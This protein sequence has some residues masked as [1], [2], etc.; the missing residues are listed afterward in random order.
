MVRHEQAGRVRLRRVVLVLGGAVIALGALV[1]LAS[2]AE[3]AAYSGR[4]LPGVRVDGVAV[5]GEHDAAARDAITRLAAELERSPIR[6]RAGTRTFSVDPALIGFTVDVD[7]T[8]QR[9][10]DA[11]RDSNPLATATDTVLRRFRPETVALAV[12]YDDASLQGL[13]DGWSNA[14]QSGF[15]EGGLRFEGTRVV[16]IV[17][18]AGVGLERSSAEARLVRALTMGPR[19]A[20]DLPIGTITPAV[21]AAAVQTAAARARTLLATPHRIVAGTTTVELT[22]PQLAATL[23]S[24]VDGHELALTVDPAQLGTV[25]TPAFAGTLQA[26]ADATFS[27]DA[28]N[29]VS[30]VPSRDG[31]ELDTGAIG[32]S[33][34]RGVTTVVATVRQSHPAHDTAWAQRLGITGQV[35]SFTTYHPAGQPRV[36]NIHLAAD[37]LN[38]TVVEPGATFS[39]NAKLGPRTPQKGY[40]KAP[41]IVEDGFGEDYGGGVS[42]LTTTLYNAVFFGGYEDTEHS[43]HHY[44]ISRYPM[45]REATINYPSVDLKFRDDTTHGVLIRTSYTA[46]SITVSLYGNN[47][48]RTVRE[49]NRKILNTVPITDTIVQ[50][51]VTDPKDDANNV[52]PTLAAG[53]RATVQSGET[54]YDVEFDR[55]IDQ[56]GRPERRQHYEVHYPMLANKILVG[57]AP[58]P[59]S[60]VP[61]SSSTTPATA[62]P[63]TAAPPT[64]RPKT[65]RTP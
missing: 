47:D 44:Y 9:V 29:T 32:A 6:T 16:P 13:L 53:E 35:S 50:C 11:G 1:A 18:H 2:W 34:L 51:P 58:T 17:P 14:L 61:T 54:G 62:P 8:M 38:N 7:A 65:K 28:T 40:V 12:H 25:L 37:V 10:R 42:Q 48:G 15:V 22:A 30:V 64:T 26:P 24:R 41:I 56:P 19:A 27:V 59:S 31:Y 36:H 39:L 57:A 45:G 21:D 4:V 43:P 55:V 49:E 33:I 23:G 46:T 5:G 60:S 52:C 63:T 3:H 20:I